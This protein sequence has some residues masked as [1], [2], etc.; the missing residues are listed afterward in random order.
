M[1]PAGT[2][3][4]LALSSGSCHATRGAQST[5]HWRSSSSWYL[6]TLRRSVK[7]KSGSR[8]LGSGHG[9]PASI[10]KKYSD[11]RLDD[12][13]ASR[14]VKLDDITRMVCDGIEVKVV[15]AGSDQDITYLTHGVMNTEGVQLNILLRTPT[16]LSQARIEAFMTHKGRR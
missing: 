5:R 4:P 16:R 14:Y 6:V 7:S 12:S 11:P 8:N 1:I 3:V 9:K 15:N 2:D 10:I 13:V